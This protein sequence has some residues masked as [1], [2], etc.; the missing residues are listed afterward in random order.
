MITIGLI[1]QR[2]E[3]LDLNRIGVKF[4]RNIL[5]VNYVST[6]KVGFS[7][8]RQKFKITVMPSFHACGKVLPPDD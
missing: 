3:I 1:T 2:L 4:D 8:G 7:I 6:E 5:H